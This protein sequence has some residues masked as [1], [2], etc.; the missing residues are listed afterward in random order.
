VIDFRVLPP[1]L[2]RAAHPDGE[3]DTKCVCFNIRDPAKR[4]KLWSD[5]ETMNWKELLLFGR[6]RV[7]HSFKTLVDRR[8]RERRRVER[9][10][11]EQ[12]TTKHHLRARK[13]CVADAR[14]YGIAR[15]LAA[16]VSLQFD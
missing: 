9:Q 5:V 16:P 8:L 6:D 10:L 7:E 1:L 13:S 15:R 11:A 14:S 12:R 3:V 2:P 4:E